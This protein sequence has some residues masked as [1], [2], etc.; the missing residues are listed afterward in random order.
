MLA[1]D[2]GVQVS[3]ATMGEGEPHRW[4]AASVEWAGAGTVP[5]GCPTNCTFLRTF[6]SPLWLVT[7]RA[8]KEVGRT[9]SFGP[10]R[11]VRAGGGRA[12]RGEETSVR[13]AFL[14]QLVGDENGCSS[15]WTAERRGTNVYWD[16]RFRKR[17]RVRGGGGPERLG[18]T[19]GATRGMRADVPG[20][21]AAGAAGCSDSLSFGCGG[22]CRGARDGAS[23]GR[24]GHR[25]QAVEHRC[26]GLVGGLRFAHFVLFFVASSIQRAH[27]MV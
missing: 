5:R 18:G 6:A 10:I 14:R 25:A 26:S 17:G 15:G 19:T 7:E 12:R 11:G 9:S 24:S 13:G 4:A 23:G 22:G 21:N 3:E 16:V 8:G 2:G 27:G 1:S 20:L